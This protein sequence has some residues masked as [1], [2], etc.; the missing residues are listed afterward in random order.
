MPTRPVTWDLDI[1]PASLL[2]SPKKTAPVGEV[3][4]LNELRA[5]LLGT[6]FEVLKI[7]TFAAFLMAFVG[8]AIHGSHLTSPDNQFAANTGAAAKGLAKVV[9]DHAAAWRG[10]TEALALGAAHEASTAAGH[11]IQTAKSGAPSSRLAMAEA[12]GS[13]VTR[14][15]DS[16]PVFHNKMHSARQPAT[17]SPPTHHSHR[18]RRNARSIVGIGT[19]AAG[20]PVQPRSGDPLSLIDYV[21]A[22]LSNFGHRTFALMRGG[23]EL[24]GLPDLRGNG[25]GALNSLRSH[26]DVTNPDSLAL[27]NPASMLAALASPESLLAAMAALMVYMVFVVVLVRVRGGLRAVSGSQTA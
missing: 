10:K 18:W 14:A 20:A 6:R 22:E 13:Q 16:A 8:V 12:K 21:S 7:S 27:R 15:A 25:E 5:S 9:Y 19:E 4:S 23:I 2:E 11:A 26:F 1:P 17:T 24:S 3:P